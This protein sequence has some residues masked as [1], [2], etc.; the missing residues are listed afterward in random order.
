MPEYTISTDTI[1]AT[2]SSLGAELISV[3][4]KDDGREYMWSAN[5]QYWKRHSPVLFPIVGRLMNDK[6]QYDGE[7]YTLTQHGFARDTE[8]ELTSKED[9]E[10]WFEMKSDDKTLT[11]YPFV[12]KLACG[13]KV[14]GDTIGVMWKVVNNSTRKMYFSIGAHPA[15]APPLG[16][17]DMTKC[18]IKFDTEKDSIWYSLLNEDGLLKEEKYELALEDKK[19]SIVENMFDQD[20]LV[21]EEN[22]AHKVSILDENEVPFVTVHFEAP[23]FGL[24]SPTGCHIPFVCIEPWYG[25]S[26]RDT[27]TGTLKDREYGNSLE[28]GKAFTA[29]YSICFQ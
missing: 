16:D 22:Q 17:A 12:F 13:Y 6:Y 26:D 28:A 18:S 25:R 21:I 20:A 4:R 5:P 19:V 15:F 3:I 23:L 9:N 11:K 24:W 10:I 1:I 14:V 2:V 8:F 29:R 27:F 7:E